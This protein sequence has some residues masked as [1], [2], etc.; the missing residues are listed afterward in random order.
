MM[1]M[2]RTTQAVAVVGNVCNVTLSTR[3]L[4]STRSMVAAPALLV[5]GTTAHNTV[6]IVHVIVSIVVVDVDAAVVI[7]VSR[8]MGGSEKNR[9]SSSLNNITLTYIATALHDIYH[10]H[11]RGIGNVVVL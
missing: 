7:I 1:E 11:H 8:L 2:C 5:H 3:R 9:G 10:H 4:S 6:A